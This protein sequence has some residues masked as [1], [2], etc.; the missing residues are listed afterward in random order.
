MSRAIVVDD[1]P[2]TRVV[3]THMFKAHGWTT[4]A[5]ADIPDALAHLRERQYDLVVCDYQLP[6]GT[7]L[8][9][10]DAVTDTE[11]AI[12]FVLLT[13]IIEYSAIP[14]GTSRR[15]A[16]R[17]TKPVSSEALRVVIEQIFPADAH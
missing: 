7:G 5:V 17:L 11:P 9:V 3:L 12:P 6:S 10:L 14:I 2:V 1:D 15:L 8:A 4:D 16:G 13:G